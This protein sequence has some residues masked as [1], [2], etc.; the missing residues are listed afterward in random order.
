MN[1]F[2]PQTSIKDT[3]ANPFAD[4]PPISKKKKKKKRGAVFCL[5]LQCSRCA[6]LAWHTFWCDR[7][8]K[9]GS[10]CLF[11]PSIHASAEGARRVS[12]P[13][14]SSPPAAAAAQHPTRCPKIAVQVLS[15]G[16]MVLFF[17]HGLQFSGISQGKISI[18]GSVSSYL[19]LCCLFI[20]SVP[21]CHVC[22][23]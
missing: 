23:H 22:M 7:S 16:G 21:V 8:R 13:L 18:S 11:A 12:S 3:T 10:R 19:R 17:K 15:E 4:Q 1:L 6:C 5:V 20:S 9:Y 14:P 2:F